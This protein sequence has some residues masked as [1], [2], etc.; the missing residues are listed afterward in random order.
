MV[1]WPS[2]LGDRQICDLTVNDSSVVFD[3]V[4][5]VWS[6]SGS[7][8]DKSATSRCCVYLS[9]DRQ[10]CDL[11]VDDSSF[12]FVLVAVDWWPS[13]SGGREIWVVSVQ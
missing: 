4:C 10:I 5:V 7:A 9:G 1:W 2:G 6:L 11:P 3:V 12:V 8:T 13:G